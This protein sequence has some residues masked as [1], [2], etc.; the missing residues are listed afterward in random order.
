[1]R[2]TCPR[3]WQ[4]KSEPMAE[5]DLVLLC[6]DDYRAGL[7]R[8]VITRVFGDEE[9]VQVRQVQ[10]RTSDGKEIKRAAA[11]VAKIGVSTSGGE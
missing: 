4:K 1:M 2:S 8:A 6:D 10:V 5:G 11:K 3:S 7:M 9:S